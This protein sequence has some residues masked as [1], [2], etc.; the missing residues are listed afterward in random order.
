LT[1]ACSETAVADTSVSLDLNL[2][3]FYFQRQNV[4]IMLTEVLL[5]VTDAGVRDVCQSV[6]TKCKKRQQKGRHFNMSVSRAIEADYRVTLLLFRDS[7]Q[8]REHVLTIVVTPY[9]IKY[10][11]T[12][13]CA[14]SGNHSRIPLSFCRVTCHASRTV[15]GMISQRLIIP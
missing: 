3:Y 10:L 8:W 2:G 11:F 5:A 15:I 13:A 1:E 6:L 14:D 12:T 9:G 7:G 4:R